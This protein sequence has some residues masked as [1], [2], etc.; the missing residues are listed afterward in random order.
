MKEDLEEAKGGGGKE[1]W[2]NDRES[3][4]SSDMA[5]WRANDF[6]NNKVNLA[7]TVNTFA[8]APVTIPAT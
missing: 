7:K 6:G 3:L 8:P 1:D 2:F 4:E 5:R